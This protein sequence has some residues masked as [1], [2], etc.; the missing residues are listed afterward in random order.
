VTLATPSHG[1][2]E[3]ADGH[4]HA[5]TRSIGEMVVL[6]VSSL[7]RL[8]S[9]GAAS[10]AGSGGSGMLWRC[11][12]SIVEMHRDIFQRRRCGGG[13]ELVCY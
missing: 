12:G 6:L 9:F 8:C 10:V 4:L 5:G 2:G 3:V 1:G 13:E 7:R 11:L